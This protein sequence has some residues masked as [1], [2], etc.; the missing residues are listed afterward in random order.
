MTGDEGED[1]ET[2]DASAT[3]HVVLDDDGL[4]ILELALTAALRQPPPL[5]GS[6]NAGDVV[7]TDGE[8]T[9]LARL[10]RTASASASLQALRPL[11][12]GQGPQWDPAVR[13]SAEEICRELG[14]LANDRPVLAIVVEEVPTIGDIDAGRRAIERAD[15]RAVL[16]VVPSARHPRARGD[17]SWAG[18]TRAANAA[19]EKVASEL[20]HVRVLPVVVPWPSPVEPSP[21]H[22]GARWDTTGLDIDSVLTEYGAT[23]TVRLVDLRSDA[24]RERV[25][26]LDGLYER[27]VRAVYPPGSAREM[28]RVSRGTARTGAVVFFTGLSGSGKSTIARALADE[29]ADGE[30]KVTL[31]DGDAVRRHLSSELG[32]DAR[33]REVNIDRTAYVASLI[34]AH[35]GIAIVALIAPFEASRRAARALVEPYGPFVLVYVNIPLEVCEARD[36]KGMYA[37][38]RAGELADFTGVSSPFEP[39]EHA[40]LVVDTSRTEVADAV[41]LVRDALERRLGEWETALRAS[42]VP[43]AGE[44]PDR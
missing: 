40:D 35:G 11:P 20:P 36:R 24:D 13:R 8:N 15:A 31:L 22:P 21:A 14:A 44:E 2:P 19:G 32:F 29:L 33:S 6:A 18:L 9:P 17:V 7:L 16:W 25:G 12:S 4:D 38:A 28:L 26:A 30:R 27:E 3:P 10:V 1:L 41:G 34:A 23:R 43:R 5:I 42:Q 39:P 37:R